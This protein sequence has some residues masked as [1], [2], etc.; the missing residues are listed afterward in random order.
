MS[1]EVVVPAAVGVDTAREG[2]VPAQTSP[3]L[4]ALLVVVLIVAV[5]VTV[6]GGRFLMGECGEEAH[7]DAVR[8]VG[9]LLWSSAPSVGL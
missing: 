7:E 4:L 3:V 8:A 2:L 9:V 1:V 5:V 6:L